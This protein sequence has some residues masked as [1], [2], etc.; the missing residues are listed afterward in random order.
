METHAY[1]VQVRA[2]VYKEDGR[3]FARS[4]EMDLVGNGASEVEALHQ[5]QSLIENHIS[6]ALFKNDESLILFPA[7][8][9]YFDRW[10]KAQQAQL[11]NGLF[12]DAA[13]K[14]H[15]KAVFIKITKEE[16]DKLRKSHRFDP[17]PESALA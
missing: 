10:E 5:L 17:M 6:F 11:R 8:R 7:E 12:P 16:L 14:M 9:E 3:Y 2:L 13:V 4:L 15:G 1:K